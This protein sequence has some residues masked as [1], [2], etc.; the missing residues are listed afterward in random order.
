MTIE[1]YE[2]TVQDLGNFNNKIN[3]KSPDNILFSATIRAQG[4]NEEIAYHQIWK[5]PENRKQ[6]IIEL[7][8]KM[9]KVL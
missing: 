5:I 6:F 3:V 2:I 1:G 8:D 9:C 7:D 4:L